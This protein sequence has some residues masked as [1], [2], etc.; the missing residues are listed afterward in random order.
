MST[1][2]YC[3][4]CRSQHPQ[5]EMRLVVSKTGKRWRCIKSIK[6]AAKADKDI[7][8]RNAYGKNITDA[9]KAEARLRIQLVNSKK[10]Q[11]N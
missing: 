10:S 9:N 3:Y 8:L 6:A 1:L 5:D 2:V 11:P 7:S 4:H